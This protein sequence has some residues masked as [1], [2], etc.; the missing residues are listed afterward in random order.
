M[1]PFNTQAP[2]SRAD[3]KRYKTVN[4]F[5]TTPTG[6]V[7][8]TYLTEEML[9]RI[10]VLLS[11]AR[12]VLQQPQVI[13]TRMR[14][15][16]RIA[17]NNVTHYIEFDGDSHFRDANVVFR[18][19]L[20]D[21]TSEKAGAKVVRIPYFVQLTTETFKHFFGFTAPFTIE[22]SFPHGFITSK[23]TPASFCMLGLDRYEKIITALPK[24]V[25][26]AISSSLE[27][28][29]QSGLPREFVVV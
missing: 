3:C 11:G 8:E 24:S 23:M 29:I 16:Y 25:S 14:Y 12:E 6:I 17:H 21:V 5:T 26:A 27:K 22:T 4:G 9:G 19:R 1:T 13:G 10:L 2:L 20:K 28:K 15:D 18:D 7:V